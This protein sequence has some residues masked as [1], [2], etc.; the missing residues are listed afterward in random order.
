MEAK[1]G[2]LTSRKCCTNVKGVRTTT[3]KRSIM[4]LEKGKKGQ[5]IDKHKIKNTEK[6]KIKTFYVTFSHNVF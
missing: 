5:L 4:F 2:L 3:R 1:K 6:R